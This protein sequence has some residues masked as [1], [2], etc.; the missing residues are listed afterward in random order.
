MIYLICSLRYFKA[1]RCKNSSPNCFVP[2]VE[3]SLAFG[4]FHVFRKSGFRKLWKLR[5][6]HA[7]K[8]KNVINVLKHLFYHCG[9]NSIM[10]STYGNL[11]CRSL[12]HGAVLFFFILLIHVILILSHIRVSFFF[13]TIL[14]PLRGIQVTTL[15]V[16]W[17][18]PAQPPSDRAG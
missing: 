4:L 9:P 10:R 12:F 3:K 14:T 6:F 8:K 16:V 5:E 11:S 2:R 1:F 18:P 13:F 17:S 7:K 15:R